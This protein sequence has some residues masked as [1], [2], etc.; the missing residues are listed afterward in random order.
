MEEE[1]EAQVE[2]LSSTSLQEE[3]IA[4]THVSASQKILAASVGGTISAIVGNTF[5]L[6]MFMC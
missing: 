3:A 1:V 6:K 2:V 5:F 4:S